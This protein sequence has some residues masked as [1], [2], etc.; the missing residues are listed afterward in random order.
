MCDSF[1]IPDGEELETKDFVWEVEMGEQ[2]VGNRLLLQRGQAMRKGARQALDWLFDKICMLL[3]PK[4]RK[5]S[6][7]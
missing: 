1:L 3:A 7:S 6:K 5:K 4:G 2:R